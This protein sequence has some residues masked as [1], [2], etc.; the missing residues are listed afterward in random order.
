MSEEEHSTMSSNIEFI[1]ALR[2]EARMARIKKDE[3]MEY[4]LG[5]A[6]DRLERL[7]DVSG[8]RFCDAEHE[9]EICDFCFYYDFNG[10]R[11]GCYVGDGVCW[12]PEHPHGCD[13][14]DECSD[15]RCKLR[16]PSGRTM[17][18]LAEEENTSHHKEK[19]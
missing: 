14:T 13:P 3:Y 15:F 7:W 4:F 19:E 8:P 1:G 16:R 2:R 17:H 9:S 18:E 11:D 6:A 12:H 10:R 5:E